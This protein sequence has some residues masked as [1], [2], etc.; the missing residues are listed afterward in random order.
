MRSR[1][2]LTVCLLVSL[3][4]GC[5]KE[6]GVGE[7]VSTFNNY[8][9]TGDLPALQERGYIRLLAPRFDEPSGLP[10]EGVPAREYQAQ[11]EAFVRHLGLQPRWVYAESFAELGALINAGAADVIVTN[12]SVTKDRQKTLAFS[13]PVNA[14]QENLVVPAE[15][16]DLTLTKL[17]NLTISVPEGTSYQ[18]TAEKLA[19]RHDNISVDILDANLSDE[20]LVEGVES[21]ELAATI[22]DSNML[23]VLISPDGEA[24]IGPVV[25]RKRR[26]A[27][28]VRQDSTELLD[29]INQYITSERV[30]SSVKEQ[31]K[32]DWSAIK[33]HGVLR[34]ITSNNPAS[35]FMWRGEL[36]G[37]DYDLIN[38][39][40]KKHRLRVSVV[41][42]DSPSAMFAA[43]QAG[44]GDVIAASMTVT[45]D[46]Q[47]QGWMFSDRYL[48]VN[49]QL[50]GRSDEAPLE[51]IGQLAGR[52]V[53]VN[54][55]TAYYDTLQKLR[56][57]DFPFI[58][59]EVPGAS[60]E[61]LINAV[62]NG[63]YDLTMADSHLAAMESTYREDIA[64]LFEFEPAKE[65][66]WGLRPEQQA[67]E[68]QLN[69]YIAR[70]YRGL[71]Y[72]ITYNRYFREKKTI[73]THEAY[74]VGSGKAISPYDELVKSEA[75]KYGLD[76]RLITSQMYQES[77]FN[78]KA[79][80]FAGAQ[81]LLQVMPRTGR[82][83]GYSNLTRP[84]N[85][86]AAG[87]AY[88]DWLEQRFPARLDLAEK[89]YFTLAAY[90]A[91]HGHVEDARRLAERLGK[92]PDKWFGNVEEAMLLLSRP[93]YARQARYGYVRGA[94]PVKYVRQIKNRYLG[95]VS[96]LEEEEG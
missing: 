9:E 43:L 50:I 35:Y 12:Y 30:I 53:A 3:L 11:A 16:A 89:L 81:G 91:G 25:N 31:E 59:Q 20:E 90:N 45:E 8:E 93:E 72:N 42:R 38:D 34:V 24:A 75:L 4:T 7:V 33:E 13:T 46:R 5:D 55:E 82:Q 37:F 92:D 41:V 73:N 22:I 86:V 48:E 23:D 88:M 80:S 79:R 54:P 36:M 74:R 49:E 87:V 64:V 84:E 2:F 29:R 44:E 83:L 68:E 62:A 6:P 51:N 47:K 85:G 94:E 56:E 52:T 66:G 95:Y 63:E 60:T 71:N 67:L 32:R 61:M 69:S 19:R 15:K 18:E 58:V 57:S 10:R 77:R 26:I 96:A 70:H 65:I 76:W 40:A 1:I 14:V 17:K 78:P 27:W 28:A 39:F 21:G